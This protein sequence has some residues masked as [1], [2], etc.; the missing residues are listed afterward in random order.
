MS[1]FLSNSPVLLSL[2]S[3]ML[4]NDYHLIKF[5]ASGRD[6]ECRQLTRKPSFWNSSLCIDVH[7]VNRAVAVSGAQRGAQPCVSMGPLSPCSPPVR[8]PHTLSGSPCAPHRSLLLIRFKC[9]RVHIL[10][11]SQT[12]WLPLPHPSPPPPSPPQ[13]TKK[14]SFCKL[15]AKIVSSSDNHVYTSVSIFL[16]QTSY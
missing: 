5:Y 6:K 16:F 4:E 12:P 8:A 14:L 7:L 1:S 10:I 2:Y 15:S 3:V 13:P 11:W 9:S